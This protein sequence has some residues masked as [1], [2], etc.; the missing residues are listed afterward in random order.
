MGDW[1]DLFEDAQDP[2]VEDELD[3]IVANIEEQQTSGVD[4][5]VGKSTATDD[6]LT[7]AG[8][9]KQRESTEAVYERKD[10]GV[11]GIQRK[12]PYY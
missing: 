7:T 2:W 3:Q 5:A 1:V 11:V 8:I 12:F 4:C 9:H 6:A 10:D